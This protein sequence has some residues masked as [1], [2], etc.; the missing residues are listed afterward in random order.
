MGHIAFAMLQEQR[1]WLWHERCIASVSRAEHVLHMPDSGART[2][3]LEQEAG[4]LR[5][6]RAVAAWDAAFG[7]V[8]SLLFSIMIAQAESPTNAS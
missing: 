7:A 8:L 6:N 3:I 4:K 1:V 2:T 5:S